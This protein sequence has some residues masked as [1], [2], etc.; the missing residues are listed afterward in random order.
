MYTLA[1]SGNLTTTVV[2]TPDRVDAFPPSA[3]STLVQRRF[4]RLSEEHSS[5]LVLHDSQRRIRC[6]GAIGGCRRAF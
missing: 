3:T 5:T 4:C 1:L 6:D 2:L